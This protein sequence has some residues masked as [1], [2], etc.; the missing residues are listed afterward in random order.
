MLVA[1][2]SKPYYDAAVMCADSIK[3]FYPEAK[4]AIYTHITAYIDADIYCQHEDVRYMFDEIDDEHDMAMTCN[5]PYNAKVVYITR[6]EELTHYKPE[7]KKMIETAKVHE[8]DFEG[9]EGC[10][11]MK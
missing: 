8:W 5:R 1:S 4:I 9:P 10:W 11:R 2:F 3:D 7:H 6:D